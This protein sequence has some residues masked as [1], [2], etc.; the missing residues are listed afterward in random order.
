[1]MNRKI[2]HSTKTSTS[3]VFDY[4]LSKLN[5]KR[6]SLFIMAITIQLLSFSFFV[7]VGKFDTG[8][9]TISSFKGII[10]LSNTVTMCVYVIIG[11]VMLRKD[12]VRFYIGEQRNRLFLFPVDRKNLFIK[13]TFS[14]QAILLSSFVTG[15]II[16]LFIEIAANRLLHFDSPGIVADVT[17]GIT[18]AVVSC[19]LVFM[20]VIGSEIIA[21]WKQSEIAT[22][23][24]AVVLMLLFSNISAIGLINFS[25]L[26]LVTVIVLSTLTLFIFDKFANSIETMEST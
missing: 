18:S 21:I 2:D 22:V 5:N 11:S 23:V 7:L 4:E 13:K 25:F 12:L 9:D 26:T 3:S 20:I 10:A 1:M 15:I 16:A 19:L 24:S 14:V 8:E 17:I 6:F